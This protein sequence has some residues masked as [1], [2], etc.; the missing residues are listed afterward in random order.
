MAPPIFAKVPED[1][2]KQYY[3]LWRKGADDITILSTLGITQNIFEEYAPAFLNYVRHK[4]IFET[5]HSLTE[6]GTPAKIEFTTER[7]GRILEY[8]AA[9]LDI[10]QV[11]RAMG[12]PLAT[13]LHQWQKD[14]P[15]FKIQCDEA[16]I[17]A[18]V[19][20]VM[21]LK[22][23]ATG[24]SYTQKTVMEQ[25]VPEKEEVDPETGEITSVQPEPKILTTVTRTEK[26]VLGE[27]NAQKFWLVNR[28]PGKWTLDGLSNNDANQG[29]LLKAIRAIV[30]VNPEENLDDKFTE[31]DM[32]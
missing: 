4:A 5:R 31:D 18:N 25:Q 11:S 3:E 6:E 19:E 23:R 32:Q 29:M 24:Y 14:D 10:Q 15:A 9:G 26:V 22:K 16:A 21:A 28:E 1:M 27:T 17:L 12:I 13:I 30:E 2:L 8:L 20:V 7:R